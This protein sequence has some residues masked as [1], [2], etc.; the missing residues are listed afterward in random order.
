MNLRTMVL[1]AFILIV[2]VGLC[3]CAKKEEPK[4]EATP[5]VQPAAPA[6]AVMTLAKG[7]T[8]NWTA[9]T[10][11]NEFKPSDRIN[12]SI[13]TENAVPGNQL[14]V[15]WIYLGTNQLVKADSVTLK[16]A[17]VNNSAFFIERAKGFPVGDYQSI[18]FLNG[19]QA[20][21]A[22]FKVVK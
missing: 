4:P 18:A 19:V 16:E 1:T 8:V 22:S 12:V 5:Q 3:G 20:K 10:P 2:A 11:T 15:K 21:S 9:I 7:V 17:G 6:V 14:L 13:K